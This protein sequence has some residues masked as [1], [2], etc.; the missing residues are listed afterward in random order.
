MN[1]VIDFLL[2]LF[3]LGISMPF[4]KNFIDTISNTAGYATALAT[5]KV[6]TTI[7][8]AALPWLIP[9]VFAIIKIINLVKT[10]EDKYNI[11][12]F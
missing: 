11:R 5:D 4:F 6:V 3:F 8:I 10:D 12:N 2:I 9:L 7:V 1:K